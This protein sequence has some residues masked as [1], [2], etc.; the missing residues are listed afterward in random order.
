MICPKCGSSNVNAQVINEVHLKD[1]HH[2]L[3]W[4][5]F[6]GWWWLPI[7]WLIFTMPALLFKLFGH[8]K[9][10]A[11]NHQETIFVCQNCGHRWS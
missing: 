9:Q 10:E 3:L 8:K 1:K 2:G 11:V 5:L 6:V 7:K 4:W